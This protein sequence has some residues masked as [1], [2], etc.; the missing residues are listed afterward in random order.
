MVE[1]LLHNI[2][3]IAHIA[4]CDISCADGISCNCHCVCGSFLIFIQR[5][6][7]VRVAGASA[8]TSPASSKGIIKAVKIGTSICNCEC[9]SKIGDG[10]RLCSFSKRNIG[11]AVAGGNIQVLTVRILNRITPTYFRNRPQ[12]IVVAPGSVRSGE[13]RTRQ[14][15]DITTISRS[16]GN[17]NSLIHKYILLAGFDGINLHIFTRSHFRWL[18]HYACICAVRLFRYF[19]RTNAN[20]FCAI[21]DYSNRLFLLHGEVSRIVRRLRIDK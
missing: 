21:E 6:L 9:R 15:R 17:I 2:D 16:V 8:R 4:D 12:R 5:P 18:D 1:I 11:V 13:R 7:F 3:G 20:F 14:P 19:I 10:K